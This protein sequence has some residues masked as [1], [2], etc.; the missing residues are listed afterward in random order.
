MRPLTVTTLVAISLDAST[1]AQAETSLGWYED[2]WEAT[3][4]EVDGG[5][6]QCSV[7][8]RADNFSDAEGAWVF[9]FPGF[10]QFAPNTGLPANGEGQVMV[11]DAAPTPIE[12]FDGQVGYVADEDGLPLLQAMAQGS[13]MTIEVWPANAPNAIV[14]YIYTLNGFREAYLRIADECQ[15]DPSPVLDAPVVI[16]PAPEQVVPPASEVTPPSTEGN[17]LFGRGSPAPEQ[18]IPPADEDAPS[19]N[20]GNSL[21]GRGTK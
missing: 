20:E 5:G 18:V 7:D 12:I 17:S 3:T 9:V 21:F 2:N 16:T 8:S 11:D 14:E 19:S 10:L 13:V 4:F 15:F 6:W 1:V